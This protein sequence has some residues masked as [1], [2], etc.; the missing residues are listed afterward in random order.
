MGPDR[1]TELRA[2]NALRRLVSA[3]RTTG[4]GAVAGQRLSVAQQF[5]IRVIGR[6]PGL[7]MGDLAAATMT[8]RSTV[9]EVVVRL[10]D[11]GLVRRARDTDDQR[12]VR[13]ELTPD[14]TTVYEQLGQTVP[15]RLV[16]ALAAMDP[17]ICDMLAE[18]L[19]AWVSSAGLDAE[20]PR[21]FGEPR[22]QPDR[23]AEGRVQMAEA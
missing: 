19:D 16:R 3:V 10:V 14:G 22:R 23:S 12:V 7:A 17:M 21:M 9:S 20:E 8:T 13:L 6:E 5:A 1:S 15:E 2:M 18:S 11:R 4:A